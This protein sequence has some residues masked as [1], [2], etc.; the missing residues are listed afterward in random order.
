M[1]HVPTITFKSL[2]NLHCLSRIIFISPAFL[3][4]TFLVTGP[5]MEI[6]CWPRF[7]LHTLEDRDLLTGFFPKGLWLHYAYRAAPALIFSHC[8]LP[9]VFWDLSSD[10]KIAVYRHF[11]WA[12]QSCPSCC[13]RPSE[14]L[15]LCIGHHWGLHHTLAEG[16]Y[17]VLS[18]G[19]A[20]PC[21]FL[22]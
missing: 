4:W 8:S 6:G 15:L 7:N 12:V 18:G 14:V 2:N 1:F 10:C 5:F 9:L 20:K 21:F 13:P 19:P 22:K 16:H 11:P 3:C 17:I